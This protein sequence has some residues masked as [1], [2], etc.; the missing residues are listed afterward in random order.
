MNK[1]H[2]ILIILA[3]TLTSWG[4]ASLRTTVEIHKDNAPERARCGTC[5]DTLD[6]AQQLATA[7][8]DQPMFDANRRRIEYDNMLSKVGAASIDANESALPETVKD[9]RAEAIKL[10]EGNGGLK[11]LVIGNWRGVEASAKA[12]E[13]AANQLA[14]E[15]MYRPSTAS[16]GEIDKIT[17]DLLSKLAT[18]ETAADA[19][20][21]QVRD[22][23]AQNDVS[24]P[25][26]T[27]VARDVRRDLAADVRRTGIA[28]SADVEGRVV[29]YPIF[30]RKITDV[31]KDKDQWVVFGRNRFRTFG[32]SAQFVV[33][34][35]GHVVFRQK[36]LDFDPTPI[37]GAGTAMARL[38]LRVGAAM[39]TGRALGVAPD[40]SLVSEGNA[41]LTPAS[42]VD[43]AKLEANRLLI[44][45]RER[46]R[47]EV[48]RSLAALL[49]D[50]DSKT[51]ANATPAEL[52]ALE[53]SL[54]SH[55][56]AYQVKSSA[57]GGGS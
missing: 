17:T 25:E 52:K 22:G 24:L 13:D 47:G 55:L 6:C 16:K 56:A 10:W 37:I 51:P 34:R 7:V 26:A 2:A 21:G 4:C 57:K 40:A 33:V 1:R 15:V 41:T 38:G 44:Q 28:S 20:A 42:V 18:Y 11:E 31:I 3:A 9:R 12:V 29:G 36:S 19:F 53:D 5:T 39:A 46:A 32:G 48:L 43:L 8:L 30:D 54:R 50:V 14:L 35:E 23:L 49:R 45:R 27:R